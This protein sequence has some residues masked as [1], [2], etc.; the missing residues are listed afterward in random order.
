MHCITN[1]HDCTLMPPAHFDDVD[2]ELSDQN[3][4]KNLIFSTFLTVVW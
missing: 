3:V 2:G 1:D 4:G